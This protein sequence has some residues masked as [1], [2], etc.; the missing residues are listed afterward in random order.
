V[1][2]GRSQDSPGKRLCL[3]VSAES[4]ASVKDGYLWEAPKS[5][6]YFKRNSHRKNVGF[7]INKWT[8]GSSVKL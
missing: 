3:T 1:L 6:Y 7:K 5:G 8:H 4:A 2:D